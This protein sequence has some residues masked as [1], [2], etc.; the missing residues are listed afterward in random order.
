MQGV[1]LLAGLLISLWI[2]RYLGPEKFGQYNYT[3][4]IVTI[5]AFLGAA[6]TNDYIIKDLLSRPQEKIS[7]LNTVFYL[8]FLFG[9]ILT[10]FLIIVCEFTDFFIGYEKL[11]I[12]SSPVIYFQAFD[13]IDSFYR[14]EVSSKKTALSRIIQ[15]IISS[16]LR[17]YLIYANA[18]LLSFV[19]VFTFE[20]VTYGII[21]YLSYLK[22]NADFVFKKFSFNKIKNTLKVSWA[23]ALVT[24]ITIALTR[25]DQ[26]I[27]ANLTSNEKLGYYSAAYR[28]IDILAIGPSILFSSLF[29]AIVNAKNYNDDLYYN[30]LRSFRRFLLA[31]SILPVSIVFF[32]S[33]NIINILYTHLYFESAAILKILIF[34]FIFISNSIVSNAWYIIEKKPKELLLKYVL[35]LCF[36]VGLNYYLISEMGTTGAALTSV[37]TNFVF[38][39]LYEVINP[40]T[41]LYSSKTRV[42]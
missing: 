20:S 42:F 28:I 19:Y 34:N 39:Y 10:T 24:T 11:I 37:L 40:Y 23:L 36:N 21:L 25:F 26:I 4:S 13:V 32:Y 3:I 15:I 41:R 6:G 2:A 8:R 30:R 9:I 29:T 33:E 35:A 17:V 12:L 38:F 22:K 1:R 18:D 27:L 31:F 7:I 16:S 5:L 14:A